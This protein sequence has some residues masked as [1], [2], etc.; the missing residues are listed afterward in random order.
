LHSA[1]IRFHRDQNGCFGVVSLLSALP[2][3]CRWW[4]P[5]TRGVFW[6]WLT[7]SAALTRSSCPA[8][9]CPVAGGGPP[10]ALRQHA[11]I[12]FVLVGTV[13]PRSMQYRGGD[14][15]VRPPMRCE[16]SAAPL[17][18]CQSRGS[19]KLKSQLPHSHR[20]E[21]RD[22]F[23]RS[24]AHGTFMLGSVK[25]PL[26]S[27]LV[28]RALQKQTPPPMA[29]HSPV[30]PGFAGNVAV[31][32]LRTGADE[33]QG[34]SHRHLQWATTRGEGR[35]ASI[36]NGPRPTGRGLTSGRVEAVRLPPRR[37]WA[38]RLCLGQCGVANHTA[39]PPMDNCTQRTQ[40]FR[41]VR[42]SR[43]HADESA[44]MDPRCAHDSAP[45]EAGRCRLPRSQWT[46]RTPPRGFCQ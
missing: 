25:D 24:I 9:T 17:Q 42:S 21:V 44:P 8:T 13:T 3:A 37:S 10:V 33:A 32:Q 2:T 40:V 12:C 11:E 34:G 36:P 39:L 15:C 41:A 28:L 7:D 18:S 20:R 31:T 30:C 16:P 5:A 6:D 14:R 43:W 22:R 46:G 27:A 4:C 19:P 26:G 38:G 35:C 1:R 23:D 45:V 29:N